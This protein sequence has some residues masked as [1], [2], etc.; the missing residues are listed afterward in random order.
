METLQTLLTLSFLLFCTVTLLSG[1]LV[2]CLLMAYGALRNGGNPEGLKLVNL[3]GE[4]TVRVFL[5]SAIST[6][7]AASAVLLLAFVRQ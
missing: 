5:I 1:A 6:G 7:I 3:M 2:G 4:I